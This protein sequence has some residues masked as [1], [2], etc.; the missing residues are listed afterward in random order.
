MRLTV[1]LFAYC[2][3]L[4]LA[5]SAFRPSAF[6][7]AAEEDDASGAAAASS[8]ES[9]ASEGDGGGASAAEGDSSSAGTN[10]DAPKKPPKRAQGT[11]DDENPEENWG[12]FYDPQ[13]VFCG[14]YD[15]YKIL[16]FDHETW[17]DNPPDAK[18]ITRSYRQLSRRWHPDKNRGKK[19]KER[20]VKI[21]RAYEILTNDE[22][23]KEYDYLRGRPDEYFDK[24][25]S[26]VLYKYAPKSDVVFVSVLLLSILSAFTYFAQKQ[27]WQTVADRLIEASVEGYGLKDGGTDE[28]LEI[29]EKALERLAAKRNAEA[30]AE[31][32][33]GS[34]KKKKDRLT[35]KERREKEK[36]ELRPFVAELVS[37]IQD[38]G[39]GHHQPTW[40][41][42]LVVKLVRMPPALIRAT[43]T[44][45]KYWSRRMRG[46]PLNDEER[47]LLTRRAVG[48]VAWYASSEEDRKEMIEREVWVSS[49]ALEDWREWV[50]VRKLGPG[51]Q[52]RYGRWKKKQGSKLE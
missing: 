48:E 36:D 39:A 49:Q 13:S 8:P 9:P 10:D 5:L 46:L 52:K 7:A 47:E 42:L 4:A 14:D 37:E 50:E 15:C 6:V 12:T 29:R 33:S 16:G 38:F 22:K 43:V 11:G 40:R 28:S 25:G 20:F 1:L 26:N 45:C 23:R 24:Y 2:L 31:S 32:G 35:N 51:Y 30:E 19:A 44:Q 34:P 3:L 17:G 18:L 21:N 41:D 27:K